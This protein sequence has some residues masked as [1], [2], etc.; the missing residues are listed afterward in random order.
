MTSYRHLLIPRQRAQRVSRQGVQS[1]ITWLSYSGFATLEGSEVQDALCVH[2]LSPGPYA[3]NLFVEGEAP[4]SAPAFER[5]TITVGQHARALHRQ[6]P[7]LHVGFS[8]EF[9]GT[10][11]PTLLETLSERLYAI[12]AL[13][14]E[15]LSNQED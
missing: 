4:S 11:F 1:L 9:E 5:M 6:E 12:M 14:S 2:S 3:H 8:L 7:G 15:L 10:P 13:R